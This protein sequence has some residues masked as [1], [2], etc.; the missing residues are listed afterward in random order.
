[1][2][3]ER[4]PALRVHRP[5]PGARAALRYG[6]ALL[7]AGALAAAPP[8][9][10]AQASGAPAAGRP[11][12]ASP[13]DPGREHAEAAREV[14]A[15]PL[16]QAGMEAHEALHMEDGSRNLAI[17]W[18]D[19]TDYPR[20]VYRRLTKEFGALDFSIPLPG[21]N[22]KADRR[23]YEGRGRVL[24][25][26][27][28]EALFERLGLSEDRTVLE[29]TAVN[30]PAS[31]ADGAYDAAG[32]HS[33]ALIHEKIL[34]PFLS[35]LGLSAG[36][37]DALLGKAV[38]GFSDRARC[39]ACLALTI[40]IPARNFASIVSYE[41]TEKRERTNRIGAIVASG[42]RMVK[43][44]KE[45]RRA[46]A[47]RAMPVGDGSATDCVS[48]GPGG[49]AGPVLAVT[50]PAAS[51]GDCGGGR[52][53]VTTGSLEQVL[54][55]PA[56]AGAYGGVDFA[57]L[58]MRYL[59]DGPGGLRYAY[60]ATAL[61]DEYQR[62]PGLGARV[63]RDFGA[64][65][66]TWLAL[67][68][69]TFWVNLNPAEPDRIVDAALGRTNAGRVLL[70]ADLRMKRTKAKVLHPDTA[71]GTRFWREIR[72]AADGSL[73]LSSR[74]WIVP[75]K[76]EVHEDGDALHIL[77]AALDVKTESLTADD[78]SAR[79]CRT[80]PAADAHNEN[81]ERTLVLPE[82]TKA[83]NTA[84]EYA[85]LRRAF[86]ARIVAQ[87]VRERHRRGHR[88][89]FDALI[90]SGAPGESADGGGRTPKEVF[91][92]YVHSYRHKEF[93]LTRRTTEGSVTRVT[94]YVYG[95]A[96]FTRVALTPVGEEEMRERHPGAAESARAA[97]DRQVTG[98]DGSVWLGG[99]T[100]FAEKGFWGGL[101]DDAVRMTGGNTP[102]LLVIALALGGFLLGRRARRRR[103]TRP[104]A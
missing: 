63:V 97:V 86:R 1:M 89:S 55:A 104:S 72:T 91:D 37:V 39:P 50:L 78:P 52:S 36:E 18:F 32:V 62:D 26:A 100:G 103:R 83:V 35:R 5:F 23:R 2:R 40:R 57:T 68:P 44:Y 21:S 12:A 54:D 66:R 45:R 25:H 90:G 95:G 93:D 87:W 19:V 59:S 84:P 96:D 8:A 3:T 41:P 34:R 98:G 60:S 85:P 102:V 64:D 80:D 28:K 77:R 70:E 31:R 42:V 99:T 49:G 73:C 75:G 92:D 30:V 22:R 38:G 71:T 58:E 14:M 4:S 46:E 15:D 51:A 81:L 79:S 13:A 69:Q 20:P 101:K 94:R 88:T 7:T 9:P 61:P 67:D 29:L 11:A 65:L 16:G 33:E 6:A 24:R 10:S 56:G 47:R 43:A 74:M 82:I 27:G 48:A 53:R 76:V 17:I